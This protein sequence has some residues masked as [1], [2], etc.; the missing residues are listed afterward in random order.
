VG[1]IGCLISFADCSLCI[2][3]LLFVCVDFISCYFAECGY[4]I[5]R[6]FWVEFL[7]SFRYK[8]S[9]TSDKGLITRIHR[10]FKKL[11]SE[12]INKIL[13]KWAYELN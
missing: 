9:Y 5:L 7:G 3:V 1:G 6:I 2:E 8:N 13:N 4:E 11:T 10:E 12:R